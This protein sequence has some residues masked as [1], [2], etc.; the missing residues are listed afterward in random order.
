MA[1]SMAGPWVASK[2]ALSVAPRASQWVEKGEPWAVPRG[3]SEERR[4][5][6]MAASTAASKAFLLAAPWVAAWAAV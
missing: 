3:A 1:A 2:A 4:A 5:A 6:T